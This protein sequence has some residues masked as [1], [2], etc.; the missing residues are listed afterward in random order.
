[1]CSRISVAKL[2]SWLISIVYA[3]PLESVTAFQ[4]NAT[5]CPGL[6]L[7]TGVT[8]AGASGAVESMKKAKFSVVVPSLA[9]IVWLP[10][11]AAGTLNVAVKEPPASLL[12]RA[13]VTGAL[14]KV[15]VMS[16]FGLKPVPL[17]VRDMPTHPGLLFVVE[18]LIVALST[19]LKL[20][21]ATLLPSLAVNGIAPALVAGTVNW[22]ANAPLVSEVTGDGVILSA[23]PL[24][25]S[26]MPL[27]GANPVPVTTMIS[28]AAPE[29][30][31]RLIFWVT[32]SVAWAEPPLLSVAWTLQV[33]LAMLITLKVALPLPLASVVTLVG[34]V[35]RTYAVV[36]EIRLVEVIALLAVNPV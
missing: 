19:E 5:G 28:P 21:V 23:C 8:N 27:L 33:P 34:A 18:M 35:T 25:L 26:V 32:V 22:Q 36:P 10:E 11:G 20:R 1:M 7:V 30:L 31:L 4:V 9:L 13:T 17:M 2:W 6:E 15:T 12:T 29:E 3:T 16:L 14:A 24:Y